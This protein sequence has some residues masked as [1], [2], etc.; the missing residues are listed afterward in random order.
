VWVKKQ[1]RVL[2]ADVDEHVGDEMVDSVGC[3]CGCGYG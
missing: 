1:L 3:K 2:V